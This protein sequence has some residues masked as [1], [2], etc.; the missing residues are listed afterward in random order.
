MGRFAPPGIPKIESTFSFFKASI[1]AC[2]PEI[3]TNFYI[4][5]SILPP[6]HATDFWIATR[7]YLMIISSDRSLFTIKGFSAIIPMDP[8]A[9]IS[10]TYVNML[11]CDI[12]L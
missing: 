8:I 1:S 2:A 10:K 5:H 9:F 3:S 7:D 12:N 6:P 11:K 4:H